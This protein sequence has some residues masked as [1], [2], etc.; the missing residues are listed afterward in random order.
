M[1]LQLAQACLALLQ[2][3]S[4]AVLRSRSQFHEGEFVSWKPVYGE[5]E[6]IHYGGP[7]GPRVVDGPPH[8]TITPRFANFD[9]RLE[10]H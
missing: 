3:S 8:L 5:P 2:P 6:I 1:T 7:G 4:P 10:K 9:P